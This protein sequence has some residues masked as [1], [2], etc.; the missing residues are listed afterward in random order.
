MLDE[1]TLLAIYRATLERAEPRRLIRERLMQDDLAGIRDEEVDLVAMGKCASGLAVGAMEILQTRRTL[2]IV[3]AGYAGDASG[4]RERGVELLEGSHPEVSDAS[5][6]AG[7]RVVEFVRGAGRPVVFIISGGSSACVD[8]PL[9]PRFDENDLAAANRALIRS[10]LP[11]AKINRVRRRLSAIKGGRLGAAAE[12]GSVTMVYSDVSAGR[13]EDVGSGPTLPDGGTNEEAATILE[14][15]GDRHCSDLAAR[16]RTFSAEPV[17]SNASRS[18]LVADNRALRDIAADEARARGIDAD[19]CSDELEDDVEAGAH[20]LVDRAGRLPAERLLVAGG[21]P[22]VRVRGDGIGGR[23]SELAVRFAVA[24][25]ATGLRCVSLF[26]SSDGLDGN[27][28]AAGILLSS[29]PIDTSSVVRALA[30]SDT[31]P[32][33][34]KMGTAVLTGATGNNLRDLYLVARK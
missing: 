5:F 17:L 27:S 10:G 21:E 33:A 3:P 22:T 2:V 25:N 34:A 9:R 14:S 8:M 29:P 15:L 31:Y 20:T 24:C 28:G 7:E 32:L 4:I 18:F 26:A 23:C 12:R 16:L 6:R 30:T 11:I 1:H 19:V 13:L